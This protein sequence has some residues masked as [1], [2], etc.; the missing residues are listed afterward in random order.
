MCSSVMWENRA[1]VFT[2][3]CVP[4]REVLSP[5]LT[6]LRS[7]PHQNIPK[8]P[9]P[10]QPLPP[11]SLPWFSLNQLYSWRAPPALIIILSPQLRLGS[12][13]HR[14]SSWVRTKVETN[15]LNPF[16][17][18]TL[19]SL[20]I[21]TY[22]TRNRPFL[23]IHW[24]RNLLPF[25][26]STFTMIIRTTIVSS[27]IALGNERLFKVKDHVKQYIDHHFHLLY[28]IMFSCTLQ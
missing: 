18:T 24:I 11:P 26:L 10:T 19:T 23:V 25:Y 15:H 22:N 5:R 3:S 7:T 2:D 4:Q 16:I 12:S 21:S 1:P 27:D 6:L 9:L 13:F 8:N 20:S 28:V 17:C 14:R